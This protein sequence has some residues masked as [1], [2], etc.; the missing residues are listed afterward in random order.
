MTERFYHKIQT[1]NLIPQIKQKKTLLFKKNKAHLLM[2]NFHNQMS[3]NK[4]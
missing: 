3:I 4:K 1:I 2:I